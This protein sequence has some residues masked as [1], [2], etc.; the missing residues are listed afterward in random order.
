[1]EEVKWTGNTGSWVSDEDDWFFEDKEPNERPLESAYQKEI[2]DLEAVKPFVNK[3]GLIW[4]F[5]GDFR[6][7]I[8]SGWQKF[9][10]RSTQKNTEKALSVHLSRLFKK[11]ILM[12]GFSKKSSGA[13]HKPIHFMNTF[14]EV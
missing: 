12:G 13:L 6:G 10:L 14:H 3:N 4:R 11:D 7:S 1:M 8:E 9:P 2:R 5:G